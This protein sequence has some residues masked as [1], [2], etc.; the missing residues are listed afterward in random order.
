[1]GT[2]C[3]S[4]LKKVMSALVKIPFIYAQSAG[5]LYTIAAQCKTLSLNYLNNLN[6]REILRDYM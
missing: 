1:M 2:Q 6:I 5:N 3:I 4:T